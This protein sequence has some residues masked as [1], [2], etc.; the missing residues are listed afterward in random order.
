MF[1]IDALKSLAFSLLALSHSAYAV[2]QAQI[3]NMNQYKPELLRSGSILDKINKNYIPK[4]VTLEVTPSGLHRLDGNRTAFLRETQLNQGTIPAQHISIKPIKFEKLE[5]LAPENLKAMVPLLKMFIENIFNQ[6]LNDFSPSIKLSNLSYS[7]EPQNIQLSIDSAASKQ[8]EVVFNVDI[9]LEQFTVNI[10]SLLYQDSSNAFI[11]EIGLSKLT[12]AQAKTSHPLHII[13]KVKMRFDREQ[14]LIL[15]FYEIKGNFDKMDLNVTFDDIQW[16]NLTT[17]KQRDNRQKQRDKESKQNHDNLNKYLKEILS[18]N[19]R[20]IQ[21]NVHKMISKN[22]FVADINNIASEIVTQYTQFGLKVP[23]LFVQE[24]HH[25]YQDMYAGFSFKNLGFINQSLILQLDGFVESGDENI[26]LKVKPIDPF[27]TAHYTTFF[28]HQT[29]ADSRVIVNVEVLNRYLEINFEKG[30]LHDLSLKDLFTDF[31][32]MDSPR[33]EVM[34]QSDLAKEGIVSNPNILYVK[35]TGTIKL[36]L[37]NSDQKEKVNNFATVNGTVLM[38]FKHVGN[39]L[40]QVLVHHI[41]FG[42]LVTV[43]ASKSGL[44]KVISFLPFSDQITEK[45]TKMLIDKFNSRMKEKP[46]NLISSLNLAEKDNHAVPI[47]PNELFG[48]RIKLQSITPL[49]KE[50]LSIEVEYQYGH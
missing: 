32:F 23:S 16:K 11:G 37:N 14:K 4:A 1:K 46:I 6:S 18:Q 45:A 9:S 15:N 47:I 42:S 17:K 35:G 5:T 24:E 28:P 50:L 8:D 36:D 44:Q 33:I 38:S 7:I 48:F 31:S 22:E 21:E 29:Q 20:P 30:L 41:Y 3:V 13:T 34:P 43:N 2:N 40:F 10:G 26:P 49:S 19:L 27:K 12:T 25:S 39:N